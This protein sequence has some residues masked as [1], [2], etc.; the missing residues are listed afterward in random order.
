L[1]DVSNQ[2]SAILTTNAQA[3]ESLGDSIAF[4]SRF[5]LGR[6]IQPAETRRFG[7]QFALTKELFGLR[8]IGEDEANAFQA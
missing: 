3:N 1:R 6:R 7:D 5:A 4:P 8:S 2:D